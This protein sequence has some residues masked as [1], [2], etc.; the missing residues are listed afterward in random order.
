MC[1]LMFIFYW[2]QSS[3]GQERT[4]VCKQELSITETYTSLNHSNKRYIITVL[5]TLLYIYIY[6]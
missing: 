6:I 2:M 3:L 5:T 1:N 4:N